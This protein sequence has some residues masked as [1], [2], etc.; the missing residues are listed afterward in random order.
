MDIALMKGGDE[1]YTFFNTSSNCTGPSTSSYNPIYCGTSTNV[2]GYS[3]SY[4]QSLDWYYPNLPQTDDNSYSYYN[5]SSE[6]YYM[7]A[8]PP[9]VLHTSECLFRS[10]F[11]YPPW[12]PPSQDPAPTV[13]P[14]IRITPTF[15]L[16]HMFTVSG[17]LSEAAVNDTDLQLA[18]AT[19][20][21]GVLDVPSEDCVCGD[22]CLRIDTGPVLMSRS[23]RQQELIVTSVSDLVLLATV[24]LTLNT[25]DFGNSSTVAEA[26]V[27]ATDLLSNMSLSSAWSD[28]ESTVILSRS[29][30]FSPNATL[31]STT[32]VD[33]VIGNVGVL[34]P[35]SAVPTMAPTVTPHNKS[36]FTFAAKLGMGI[37]LGALALFQIL[38]IVFCFCSAD[39]KCTCQRT[40]I[41]VDS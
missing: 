10:K 26:L 24:N 23:L 35:S 25:V 8:Q 15:H 40:R 22:G 32:A 14:T 12:Y 17:V 19:L 6:Y 38:I 16:L 36:K 20:S 21:C 41:A 30:L 39:D 4:N 29:W 27:T 34:S 2:P 28:F 9:D 18:V 13:A 31:L 3:Y 7:P 1:V 5:N 33:E 11:V 37:S